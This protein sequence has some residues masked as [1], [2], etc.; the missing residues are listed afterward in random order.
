MAGALGV[1]IAW[2]EIKLGSQNREVDPM[3][4]SVSRGE[5]VESGLS[6]DVLTE[7]HSPVVIN[8]E[9]REFSVAMASPSFNR[10]KSRSGD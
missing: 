5:R 4:R 2:A 3:G 9:S 6:K 7:Q 10:D 8:S 1:A